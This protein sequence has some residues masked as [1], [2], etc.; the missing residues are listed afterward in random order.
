MKKRCSQFFLATLC[1]LFFMV[2]L[3]AC[4][5]SLSESAIKEMLT[6]NADDFLP[7]PNE[8]I[9]SIEITKRDANDV[10]ATLK[11]G[12]KRASS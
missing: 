9:T 11:R 5:P 1:V 6:E 8:E 2:F 7:N 10:N 4:S 12:Q 3:S